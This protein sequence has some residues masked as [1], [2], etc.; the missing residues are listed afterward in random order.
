MP[1]PCD[2]LDGPVVTPAREALDREDV[3][4][5]LPYVPADAEG[6]VSSAY[7]RAIKARA[8]GEEAR[9]VAELWFFETVVRLHR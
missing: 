4:L 9:E 8:Q 1:P 7:D 6:E 5:V 3:A 2:S